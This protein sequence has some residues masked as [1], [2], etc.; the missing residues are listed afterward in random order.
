MKAVKLAQHQGPVVVL[1]AIVAHIY[2]RILVMIHAQTGI[3]LIPQIGFVLVIN[4]TVSA[5]SES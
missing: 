3:L 4:N 1:A 5:N 2:F